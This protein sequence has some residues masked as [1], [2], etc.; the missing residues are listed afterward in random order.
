MND[1]RNAF[2]LFVSAIVGLTWLLNTQ[3]PAAA[4]GGPKPHAQPSIKAQMEKWRPKNGIYEEFGHGERCGESTD[5]FIE[6]TEK[7]IAGFEYSCV[8]NK[9]TDTAPGAIKLDMTCADH[10]LAEYIGDPNPN[11]RTFKE[12]VLLKKI[13]EKTIFVRKTING[14]FKDPA[15]KASYCPEKWQLAERR[16]RREEKELNAREKAE[17]AANAGKPKWRP[18]DGVYA[19][20]D[21]DFNDRCAAFSD[22]TI[23]LSDG[24]IS[25]G[26]SKCKI[27]MLNDFRNEIN[28]KMICDGKTGEKS[29]SMR[30]VD[31]S[32]IYLTRSENGAFE[33]AGPVSYCPD[34]VQRAFGQQKSGK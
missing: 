28:V 34:D 25:T 30:R 7:I 14:R 11:D 19:G 3:A 10:N 9:L 6:L 18:R 1:A 23:G 16:A 12:T 32:T 2:Q 5:L 27:L 24:S 8:I 20:K 15:W 17:D 13:D 31:D 33:T 4:Q 29:L 26:A 22:V 21:K